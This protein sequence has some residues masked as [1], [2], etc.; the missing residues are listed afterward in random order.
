MEI[1]DDDNKLAIVTHR[2]VIES[3]RSDKT[4]DEID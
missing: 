2:I 3:A 1:E 4:G